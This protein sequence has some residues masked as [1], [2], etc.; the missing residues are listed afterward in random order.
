MRNL[1]TNPLRLPLI[2][3]SIL[4]ADFANMGAECRHVLAS[5]KPAP[6]GS[7]ARFAASPNPNDPWSA[8][9][10]PGGGADLLHVDVMDAHFV[11]N[12]TMGPDMV[13]AV[14]RA[15]PGGFLDVH[16]MVTDPLLLAEA[17]VSAGADHITFH[18]EVMP[19]TKVAETA[20]RIRDLGVT[21]GL[22][23]NP[24]TSADLVLPHI[25]HFD[26]ILVMSVNPGRSGQSFIPSVLEKTTRISEELTPYQRLQ[27]DGGIKVENIDAVLDAGCDV[28]VAASAIFG[29]P[30]AERA[31]VVRQLRGRPDTPEIVH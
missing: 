28:V 25:E 10:V 23:L 7:A 17:F 20:K 11:P 29:K 30:I 4:S 31:A 5:S 14:R 26:L 21:V 3:P 27:M 8:P 22:A 15:C 1:F 16:V 2:A 19:P 18:V 12:L 13:R 24:P 6:I 9:G